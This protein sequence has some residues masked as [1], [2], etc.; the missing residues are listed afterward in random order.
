MSLITRC[1]KC[2][3]DFMVSLEQLRVHDGLVRCGN[4]THIFDG[5][6]TLKSQLP[7][8]TQRAATQPAAV[9]TT[10]QSQP[11]PLQQPPSTQAPSWQGSRESLRAPA[12]EL[13]APS[14]LRRRA[15]TGAEPE[16][17]APEPFAAVFP[18]PSYQ[19]PTDGIR[20]QLRVRGEAR[21]RGEAHA[22]VGRSPPDFLIDETPLDGLR[23]GLWLLLITAASLVLLAQLAYV[24]RNELVTRVP[25]LLP[26]A[27]AAC[28]PL[29]CA[30]SFV[31]H[32]ERITLE[33]TALEQ[34]PGGQEEGQPSTLALKFSMRNRYDKIQPW[35]H[36]SLE[37]RDASGTAVIRKVVPPEQ[38]LPQHLVGRPFAANQEI[39]IHLPVTVSGLQISGFQLYSFFP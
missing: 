24:Y 13:G 25:S 20:P 36:L 38:Y 30:V 29:K 10:P 32:L 8:L 19:D 37:L 11:Q 39:H 6:A 12:Q 34:A 27:R 14:V 1:P 23:K 16:Y 35:P 9:P 15:Q 31:R 18:E 28:E 33:A 17:T 2:Q 26:L 21:L 7:T 5:H 22:S 4:C 3:S